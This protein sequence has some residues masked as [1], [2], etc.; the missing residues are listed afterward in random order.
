MRRIRQTKKRQEVA[1]LK[2]PQAGSACVLPG[3]IR[4][5]RADHNC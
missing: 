1:P 2:F 5:D 3:A 4:P